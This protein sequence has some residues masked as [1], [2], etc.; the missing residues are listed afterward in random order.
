MSYRDESDDWTPE[1]QKILSD[2]N[3]SIIRKTLEDVGP[4]ILEHWFYRDA[5]TPDRFI[6]DDFSDFIEYV[7]CHSQPGDAFRI[8][9][10]GDLCKSENTLAYGKFP[11]VDGCVPKKGPY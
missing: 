1:G 3:L 10:F 5:R 6:F 9:S 2:E 8:W 7:N 11:D 4:I